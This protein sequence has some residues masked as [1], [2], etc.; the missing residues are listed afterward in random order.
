M[1][2]TEPGELLRASTKGVGTDS[3][4][5]PEV[6]GMDYDPSAAD[7]WS[8]GVTLLFMVSAA[9]VYS[10]LMITATHSVYN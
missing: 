9:Y 2:V 7:V 4:R 1:P 6:N 10:S 8:L 3:Y 5:A